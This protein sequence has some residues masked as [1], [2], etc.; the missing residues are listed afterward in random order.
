MSE[1]DGFRAT[2]IV[3]PYSY[4]RG[5]QAGDGN[6]DLLINAIFHWR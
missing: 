6:Q 4:V 5:H 3:D 1:G 2:M